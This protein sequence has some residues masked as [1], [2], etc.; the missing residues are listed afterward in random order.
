ME[1]TRHRSSPAKST[2]D[3]YSPPAPPP[4]RPVPGRRSHRRRYSDSLVHRSSG[5]KYRCVN[6]VRLGGAGATPVV[7][8]CL[9]WEGREPE[10]A[11]ASW[12]ELGGVRP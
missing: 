5:A 1:V 10:E 11:F 3:Y 4:A 8:L 6:W 12:L 2:I 9:G 7:G